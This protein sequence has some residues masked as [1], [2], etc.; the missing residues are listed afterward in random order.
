MRGTNCLPFASTWVHSWVHS[1]VHTWV[2]SWFLVESVLLIILV[3]CVVF[4]ALFVFVLCL[5][6]PMLLGSLDCPFLITIRCSSNVYWSCEQTQLSLFCRELK[7]AII[8]RKNV[9]SII[10]E[11][12]SIVCSCSGVLKNVD[13]VIA[14]I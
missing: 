9:S 8:I 10:S 13:W 6:Y 11:L 2:H 12:N 7:R 4:F 5:V 3:V 1:W 14:L